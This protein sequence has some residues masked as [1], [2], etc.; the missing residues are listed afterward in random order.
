MVDPVDETAFEQLVATE[1]DRLPDWLT[2]AVDNVVVMIEDRHPEGLLGL[3]EGYALTDRAQYGFGELPDRVT[4]Y[5]LELCDMVADRAELIDE[6]H[7]T[8]VHELAHHLGLDDDQLH[9]LGWG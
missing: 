2:E 8:L 9:E 6:I 4:L 7:V 3:W 5:R 1:L